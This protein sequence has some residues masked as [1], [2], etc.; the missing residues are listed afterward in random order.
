MHDPRVWLQLNRVLRAEQLN[1]LLGPITRWTFCCD[2]QWLT[3]E[4]TGQQGMLT[5]MDAATWSGLERIGIV[6]RVLAQMARAE[7]TVDEVMH[8]SRDVDQLA[9]RAIQVHQLAHLDDQVAFCLLGLRVH[10]RFDAHPSVLAYLTQARHDSAALDELLAQDDAF[11][12]SVSQ[13]LNTLK[14]PRT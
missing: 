11:W 12:H 1:A 6:N 3:Q 14:E 13:S 10:Q 4:K 8:I 7:R 2:G 5:R 9:Q